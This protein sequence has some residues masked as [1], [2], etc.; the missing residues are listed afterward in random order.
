MAPEHPM[1]RLGGW[2]G[3]EVQSCTVEMRQEVSWCIVRLAIRRAQAHWCSGCL[4]RCRSIHDLEQRQVRD[5]PVFERRTLV[6]FPRIRVACPRCGPKVEL[7]RWLDPRLRVTRRLGESVAKLCE[8]TSV[9]HVARHYALNWKTVKTLDKAQL[10]RE[11]GPSDLDGLQVIGLDEFAIQKGH[12]Y[13][14]VIVEPVRKRVLW[15]GRGRSREDIRP[16]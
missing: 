3:Y 13:A 16:Q 8:V 7:L 9:L 4:N 12:R 1:A 11:L 14:T 15:V 10:A 2:E 5:L 6:V